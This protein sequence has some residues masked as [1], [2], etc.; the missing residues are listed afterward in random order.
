MKTKSKTLSFPIIPFLKIAYNNPDIG[1]LLLKKE[2]ITDIDLG[3]CGIDTIDKIDKIRSLIDG[4]MI[5]NFS[6]AFNNI[7]SV[8]KIRALGE[9]LKGIGDDITYLNLDSTYIN[10][11][12]KIRALGEALEGKNIVTLSFKHNNINSTNIINELGKCLRKTGIMNID[13]GYNEINNIDNIKALAEALKETYIVEVKGV[14]DS[15]LTKTL[16]KNREKFSKIVKD[17]HESTKPPKSVELSRDVEQL[18]TN[19]IVESNLK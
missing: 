16:E 9:A 2:K 3:K 6:I 14:N 5:S 11:V 4:T 17:L 18:T 19:F 7:N 12:L 15:L 13:L 8:P 1:N 10:S